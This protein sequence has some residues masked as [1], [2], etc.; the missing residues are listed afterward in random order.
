MGEAI[1]Q[2]LPAAVGVAIS[3]LPIIA[4]VLFVGTPRGRVNGPAF[5]LGCALGIGAIG[6]GVLLAAGGLSASDEGAPATWVSV[7]QLALGILLL[8]A[9]LRQWRGRPRTGKEVSTPRWMSALNAFGPPKAFGAGVVL[10]GINPKNLLLTVAGAAAIAQTG[11]SADEQ[12]VA[13]LVFVLIGCLGVATPVAITQVLGERSRALLAELKDWMARNN[14]VIMV[15]I[16]TL[17][18]VKLIGDA[19]TGFS[20]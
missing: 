7:L 4:S 15:V 18:G 6:A 1:G 5:V 14:A 13:L 8:A 19:I 20:S 3:P 10:G 12:A 17:L 11:I 16:L 9:A 2:M